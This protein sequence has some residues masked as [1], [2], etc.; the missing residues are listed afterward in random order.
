MSIKVTS[1][2]LVA[3]LVKSLNQKSMK[4]SNFFPLKS[5]PM[6]PQSENFYPIIQT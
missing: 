3:S 6:S 1:D 2:A 4:E 5:E